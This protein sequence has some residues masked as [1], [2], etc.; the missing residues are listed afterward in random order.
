MSLEADKRLGGCDHQ[1]LTETFS[2]GK[3]QRVLTDS[4]SDVSRVACWVAMSPFI[5]LNLPSFYVSFSI[6][7][8]R[9]SPCASVHA[10]PHSFSLP[11]PLRPHRPQQHPLIE[12]IEPLFDHEH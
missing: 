10:N 6:S 8:L 5:S 3:E 11:L 2:E 7:T 9:P 12:V 4:L 1:K